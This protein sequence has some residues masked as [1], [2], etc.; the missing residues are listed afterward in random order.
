MQ[1]NCPL[2]AVTCRLSFAQSYRSRTCMNI[3]CYYNLF[4]WHYQQRHRMLQYVPQDLGL[5][6]GSWVEWWIK[7]IMRSFW[8]MHV[9]YFFPNWSFLSLFLHQLHLLSYALSLSYVLSCTSCYFTRPQRHFFVFALEGHVSCFSSLHLWWVT[10]IKT[11][12]EI[13]YNSPLLPTP[14]PPTFSRFCLSLF[15]L[16]IPPP[17]FLSVFHCLC[18]LPFSPIISPSFFS[19]F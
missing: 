4:W 3:K 1:C 15:P 16:W 9:F 10:F 11:F 17:L 18:C 5:Y 7:C 19:I 12:K 2:Q 13:T 6:L 8:S 14:F